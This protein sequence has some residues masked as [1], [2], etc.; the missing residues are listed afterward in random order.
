MMMYPYHWLVTK[1]TPYS[2]D[3][4]PGNIVLVHHHNNNQTA[5]VFVLAKH[6]AEQTQRIGR[7]LMDNHHAVKTVAKGRITHDIQYHSYL[8]KKYPRNSGISKRLIFMA[9]QYQQ[10]RARDQVPAKFDKLS[11]IILKKRNKCVYQPCAKKYA[12]WLRK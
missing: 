12:W 11:R 3:V 2:R 10:M 1:Q 7:K 9:K 6:D 4:A 5:P 8:T